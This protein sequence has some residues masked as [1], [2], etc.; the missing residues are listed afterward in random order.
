MRTLADHA[1]TRNPDAP[2]PDERERLRRYKRSYDA[3]TNLG[4]DRQT[5]NRVA[6]VEWL[7]A[8]GDLDEWDVPEAATRPWDADEIAEWRALPEGGW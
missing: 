5:G 3:S 1:P 8:T 4:C 6:F 2:A 7:A